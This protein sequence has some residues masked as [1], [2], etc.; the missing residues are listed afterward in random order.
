MSKNLCNY[1]YFIFYL[2]WPLMPVPSEFFGEETQEDEDR[3]MWFYA[4]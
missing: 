2:D 1:K 4:V 3:R